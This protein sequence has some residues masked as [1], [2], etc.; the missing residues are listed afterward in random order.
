[1]AV[2]YLSFSTWT[3]RHGIHLDDLYVDPASRGRGYGTALLRTLARLCVERGY[4]RFE[5][6]V[7]DWNEPSIGFYRSLGAVPVE[8]WAV[9]RL[10]GP[11][12]ESLGSRAPGRPATP[13]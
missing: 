12:L 3:G 9:Y 2:W 5:W 13:R 1:V 8:D 6:A 7:L 10:A 4:A 11:A